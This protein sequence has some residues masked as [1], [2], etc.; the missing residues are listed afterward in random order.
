[1]TA[2]DVAVPALA[3]DLAA[4]RVPFVAALVVRAEPPTSAHPGDRALVLADGEVVG[5]VGGQ[6][7]AG[8]VRRYAARALDAG[9]P[10]LL[11][12]RPG[13]SPTGV[14]AAGA[15]GSVEAGVEA[16]G[17]VAVH[18]P[19]LSGGAL[20]IFLEPRLP[21]P[22]LVV[23]GSAPIA[24]ALV[25]LARCLG[26]AAIPWAGAALPGDTA[27]VVVASHG[28]DEEAPLRAAVAAGVPYV[29]LVAS[30]RRGAGVL[31]ALDLPEADRRR[32]HTPAGLDLGARTPG[33][34]A[35]SILAQVVAERP[36]GGPVLPRPAVS[37]PPA[38]TALDPVCGMTVEGSAGG[39]H[40][41]RAGTRW[42]FCGPGC[43]DAF[44][45]DPDRYAAR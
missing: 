36:R 20:D 4:R 26:Y 33:E 7:V 37:A 2:T 39:L 38:G 24:T 17:M 34:V 6:C 12:V 27:A 22:L 31:A 43:R 11:R 9:R 8:D 42:W 1:M 35:L 15:E 30:P 13:G 19:C 18:N 28:R 32:V 10:L 23:A 25:D 40:L 45:A 21:P 14:E 29:G 3:E 44:A 41:D 5:F 16:A